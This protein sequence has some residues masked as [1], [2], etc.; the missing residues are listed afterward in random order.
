[1]K[2]ILS[3]LALTT[4]FSFQVS[5]ETI[6]KSHP[7]VKDYSVAAMG[8][9]ILLDCY[10]GIDKVSPDKNFGEKFIVF[11]DEIKRILTALDKLG[12]E[13]YIANE[14]YFTRSTVGLY[15]PDYNRLFINRNLLDDPREFLGTLRHEG[16][17]TVQDCMGG[18]LE[19]AFMAQVHQDKEIPDWLRKMV[20][21][22][23]SFAGMSRAVPWEVDANWAEEQ[24]NVTAEKLEMC[25][26]GPLW[27]QITPT[28]MTK[29]WLIGCG[30]MKPKDGL[31]PYNP[32]K[33]KEYCTPGKY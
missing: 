12:I 7:Q 24:S 6:Q 9:M 31:Y 13:V 3:V 32:N 16:W 27:E 28:P 21:R 25:A 29:E 2:K 33:K 5:A 30:W 23:Y 22:T 20:E 4:M 14:R 8:C 19:T 26:K 10:E 11:K 15:K 1:M 17:H 18:G